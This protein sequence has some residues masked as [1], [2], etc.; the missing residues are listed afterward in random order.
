MAYPN[1]SD[2]SAGQPIASARYNNLR[3]DTLYFGNAA[4]D[5][6]TPGDFFARFA[7]NLSLVYL[8]TNRLRVPYTSSIKP[9]ALMINGYTLKATADIDLPAGMFSG[10][11]MTWNVFAMQSAGSTTFTITINTSPV[12]GTDQRLISQ[13]YWD[14][15]N[16]GAVI[17]YFG[18][19]GF[20]TADYDSGWFAVSASPPYPKPTE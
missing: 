8:A 14:G 2:A 10:G 4:T 6:L 3:K 15:T 11:A 20:P 19:T 16:I 7:H 13:C 17:Y 1:S 9:A 18:N 12:K 5:S